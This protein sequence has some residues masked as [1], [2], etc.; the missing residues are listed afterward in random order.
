MQLLRFA[1]NGY[2]LTQ[3]VYKWGE[4]DFFSKIVEPAN[5]TK[6]GSKRKLINEWVDTPIFFPLNYVHSNLDAFS[7]ESY[8]C[9][10]H[11][12]LLNP[13]CP[14]FPIVLVL[15]LKRTKKNVFFFLKSGKSRPSYK[16]VAILV[17]ARGLFLL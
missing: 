6:I 2:F 17:R 7:L 13:L 15:K 12:R 16:S 5:R 4:A 9:H 3:S 1:S 14:P 10:H 8:P 11:K